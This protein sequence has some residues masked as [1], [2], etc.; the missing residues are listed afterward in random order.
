MEGNLARRKSLVGSLLHGLIRAV[1]NQRHNIAVGLHRAL[2]VDILAH[3]LAMIGGIGKQPVAVRLLLQLLEYG[4][5]QF[6]RFCG[7]C[8][9]T[10]PQYRLRRILYLEAATMRRMGRANRVGATR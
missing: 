7:W 2:I 9:R 3:I 8:C 1:Q 5:N 6:G 10:Y 4:L